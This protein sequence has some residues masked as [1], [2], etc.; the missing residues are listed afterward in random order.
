MGVFHVFLN[1]KN[2]TESPNGSHIVEM[3]K[4]DL[5]INALLLSIL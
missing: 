4:K 1:C 5:D 2:G 3:T